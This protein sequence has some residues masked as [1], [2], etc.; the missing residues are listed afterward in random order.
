VL[1]SLVYDVELTGGDRAINAPL[2]G[3]YRGGADRV[4]VRKNETE[5]RLSELSNGAREK[6]TAAVQMQKIAS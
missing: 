6:S 3:Q 4:N 1:Y 5:T 2:S